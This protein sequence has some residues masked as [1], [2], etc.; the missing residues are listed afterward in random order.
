MDLDEGCSRHK[1]YLEQRCGRGNGPNE[2][3]VSCGWT[4]WLEQPG[5]ESLGKGKKSRKVG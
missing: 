4:P 3:L 5:E 2:G 1:E